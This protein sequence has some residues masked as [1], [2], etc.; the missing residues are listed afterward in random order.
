MLMGETGIVWYIALV[1]LSLMEEFHGH[2]PVPVSAIVASMAVSDVSCNQPT[3]QHTGQQLEKQ[4]LCVTSN[5]RAL[6]CSRH[7]VAW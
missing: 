6:S 5:S 4:Q 2:M 3:L 1:S 7:I